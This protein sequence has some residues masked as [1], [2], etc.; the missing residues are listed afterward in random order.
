MY[1]IF[2]TETTGLPLNYRAPVSD[3]NNWPRLV[4]LAWELYNDQ[5]EILETGNYII[6]PVD[7][8]IPLTATQI[9]HISHEEAMQTGHDLIEVL[10]KFSQALNKAQ[11]LIAH[12]ISF[13]EKILGAEFLRTG[14]LNNMLLKPQ[15]C[16]MQSSVNYCQI[17]NSHSSYKWPNLNELHFKLFSEMFPDA[18]NALVDVKAC[19]RC[20][21][22]LKRRGVIKL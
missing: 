1:L 10:N 3:L 21:F 11:Y 7:F 13:D 9:H 22:E 2:D 18:H 5:G 15:I 6:K 12:N 20:F 14:V 4:Q 17:P 19:A 16:T 8:I